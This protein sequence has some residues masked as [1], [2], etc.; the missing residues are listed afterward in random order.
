MVSSGGEDVG[1]VVRTNPVTQGEAQ[2][3]AVDARC[4]QV[5]PAGGFES[6]GPTATSRGR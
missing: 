6:P 2:R 4:T 3:C 1:K 5:D